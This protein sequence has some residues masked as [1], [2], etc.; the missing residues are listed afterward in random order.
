MLEIPFEYHPVEDGGEALL[1]FVE[2]GFCLA[3]TDWG[4]CSTITGSLN[5]PVG[6]MAFA[7][8]LAIAH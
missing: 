7:S 1:R 2:E 3:V 4:R 5:V 6:M 8:L